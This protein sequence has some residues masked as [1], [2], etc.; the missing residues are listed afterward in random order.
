L[1]VEVV[2]RGGGIDADLRHG[3]ADEI[4]RP[5]LLLAPLALQHLLG[6]LEVHLS[7]TPYPY[8]AIDDHD[9]SLRIPGLDQVGD[10]LLVLGLRVGTAA[11]QQRATAHHEDC[12]FLEHARFSSC[13]DTVRGIPGEDYNLYRTLFL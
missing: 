8:A 10:D 12:R 1:N 5:V 11:N 4:R 3:G 2:E 13:P 7:V 6:R 9:L